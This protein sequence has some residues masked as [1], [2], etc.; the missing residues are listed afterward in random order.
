[1]WENLIREEGGKKSQ[2]ILT[3][4][5]SNLKNSSFFSFSTFNNIASD[6]HFYSDSFFLFFLKEQRE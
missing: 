2:V 1:M 5:L 4:I 6:S 3:L